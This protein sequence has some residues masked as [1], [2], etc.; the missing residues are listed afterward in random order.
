MPTNRHDRTRLLVSVRDATEAADAQRAGAE[1]IDAKAPEAGPMGPVAA[2]TLGAIAG[3]VADRAW[4]T[5]AAGELMDA[6]PA[7]WGAAPRELRVA[8][9]GLARC[10]ATVAAE[11]LA[12]RIEA[13]EHVSVAVVAYADAAAA[14]APPPEA[15]VEI[16]REVGAQWLV[17][18]TFDKAGPSSLEALGEA[19]LQRL[20]RVALEAGLSTVLAGGLCAEE[21]SR[22]VALGPTL[23][24]V[25]GAACVSGRGGK[26]CPDRVR[27]LLDRLRGAAD[28]SVA[29]L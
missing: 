1:V 29:G 8:K 24:G 28:V 3:A 25:R 17:L 9:F 16:A 26:L 11:R 4:L 27:S 7:W 23:V 22:A 21:V 14:E 2:E 19:R 6:S 13:R 18:D 15:A 10:T 12:R 5:A 20:L